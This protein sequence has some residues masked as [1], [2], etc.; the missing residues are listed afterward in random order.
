MGILRAT[1]RRVERRILPKFVSDPRLEVSEP[2]VTTTINVRLNP[3]AEP[4][5]KSQDPPPSVAEVEFAETVVLVK[6]IES[7]PVEKP[8]PEIAV[9]VKKNTSNSP[10]KWMS[11][12]PKNDSDDSTETEGRNNNEKLNLTNRLNSVIGNGNFEKAPEIV[13]EIKDAEEAKA[14]PKW[15]RPGASA[16]EPKTTRPGTNTSKLGESVTNSKTASVATK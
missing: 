7:A 1:T 3:T 5:I 2:D 16:A 9:V 8:S 14:K 6:P 13:V 4:K 10:P 12:T 11:S 15:K